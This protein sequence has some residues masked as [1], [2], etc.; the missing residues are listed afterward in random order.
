VYDVR[1]NH[2]ALRRLLRT[3]IYEVHV[4]PGASRTDLGTPSKRAFTVV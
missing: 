3:G 4:T 2:A 1:Q